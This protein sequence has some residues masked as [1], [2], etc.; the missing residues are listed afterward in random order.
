MYEMNCQLIRMCLKA[1]KLMTILAAAAY[2]LLIYLLLLHW[3]TYYLNF[4]K[5]VVQLYVLIRIRVTCLHMNHC[6]RLWLKQKQH[7][8]PVQ[9]PSGRNYS[10]YSIFQGITLTISAM[11]RWCD[12]ICTVASQHEASASSTWFLYRISNWVCEQ[13]SRG[14]NHQLSM[15]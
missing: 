8:S 15:L 6:F 7:L 12:A 13:V 4:L 2:F 5:S 1:A 14:L 9:N 10:A 11:W 3:V